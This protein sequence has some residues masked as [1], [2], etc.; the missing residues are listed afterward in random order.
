MPNQND[1]PRG[2]TPRHRLDPAKIVET[3]G[4][5][6]AEIAVRLPGTTLAALAGELETIALSAMERGRLARQPIVSIRL[7]SAAAI[8]SAVSALWY[9][10]D[11][12]HTKWEFG[13]INEVFEGLHTGFELVALFA[14]AMWFCAT[15]ELRIKRK[16]ALAFIEELREFIHVIDVTQL[17]FTP[18]LYRSRT[19]AGPTLPTLDETYLLYCTQMLAVLGNL[20]PLYTRGA[21]E[22]SVLRAAADVETLAI[23]V[24][25]KHLAKAELVRAKG[26]G[27]PV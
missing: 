4:N 20:A 12:I 3:A 13:T 10:A 21:P 15:I 16:R 27:V 8:V 26:A 24:T 22:D 6:A 23:A 14:G 5:L 17:Y 2:S 25:T 7:L 11:H 9:L 1:Q 19:P 18:D